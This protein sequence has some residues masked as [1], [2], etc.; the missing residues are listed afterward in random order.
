METPPKRPYSAPTASRI[1]WPRL[2]LERATA[3]LNGQSPWPDGET[4]E[5]ASEAFVRCMLETWPD[6]DLALALRLPVTWEMIGERIS[7]RLTG[8]IGP[9]PVEAI[10]AGA[11][12]CAREGCNRLAGAGELHDQAGRVLC[13]VHASENAKGR[14]ECC[15]EAFVREYA[16]ADVFAR[17][18]QFPSAARAGAALCCECATA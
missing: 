9:M 16:G 18:P 8:T 6:L 13:R 3:V 14:C 10:H 4:E 15:G 1:P 11:L 7:R 5:P 17:D 12:R 2:R